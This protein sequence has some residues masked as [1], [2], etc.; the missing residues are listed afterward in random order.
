MTIHFSDLSLD[1]NAS[2]SLLYSG[3][4][5]PPPPPP[6]IFDTQG[7]G[8]T[9]PSGSSGF[10]LRPPPP[11]PAFV[12]PQLHHRPM[13]LPRPPFPPRSMHPGAPPPPPPP[14]MPG[15]MPQPPPNPNMMGRLPSFMQN[16][17]MA[18]RR[19]MQ[20]FPFPQNSAP[21]SSGGGAVH[22]PVEKPKVVYAA[23]PMKRVIAETKEPEKPKVVQVVEKPPDPKKPHVE[24]SVKK[25]AVHG[26]IELNVPVEEIEAEK[27]MN[28]VL[29]AV[30]PSTSVEA[31]PAP[32]DGAKKKEKKKKF[33]RMAAS[34]TWEDPTLAEWELG[35][36]FC[37][38]LI[39]IGFNL[40]NFEA[41]FVTEIC[42]YD[43]CLRR[44]S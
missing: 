36:S 29:P 26:G 30:A 3:A 37:S 4:L 18:M 39:L 24:L 31:A 5:P 2:F 10:N 41:K 32:S 27:K 22:Q 13:L 28:C 25:L 15:M 40:N 6:P 34:S 42:R 16:Q 14:G 35:W 21:P 23:P 12:P 38:A 17:M 1:S 44:F 43:W 20:P 11:P 19:S 33:V 9:P 7:G 8:M